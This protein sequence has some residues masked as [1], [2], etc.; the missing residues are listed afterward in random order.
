MTFVPEGQADSSQDD[1]EEGW[2]TTLNRYSCLATIMLSLWD[3]DILRAEASIK[4]ALMGSHPRLDCFPDCRAIFE[5]HP[6]SS[7]CHPAVTTRGRKAA[8]AF[9]LYF[10]APSLERLPDGH[11][12]RSLK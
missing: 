1:E 8:S 6:G 3:E 4:L 11:S 2:N 7:R 10:R 5:S 9:S 12:N